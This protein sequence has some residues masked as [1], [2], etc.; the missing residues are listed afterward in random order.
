MPGSAI[1]IT[2]KTTIDTDVGSSD[3]V[4][5]SPAN[6]AVCVIDG[7]SVSITSFL[8]GVGSRPLVVLS[9][10][11]FDLMGTIDVASHASP[12]QQ[13][14]G[15]DPAGCAGTAA[16]GAPGGGFGGTFTTKGGNGGVTAPPG[17]VAQ[18]AFTTTT[19]R[20]GCPGGDGKTSN[21]NAMAG[22]GGGAVELIAV[23]S[24]VLFGT[25]NASGAGG[26]PG[27]GGGN[28]GYGAGAG[29]MIVLDSPTISVNGITQVFAN[30]GGAGGGG[31]MT[32]GM[33]GVSGSDP[34]GPNAPAASGDGGGGTGG[35]G[36]NG[37]YTMLNGTV[38]NALSGDDGGGGGG[39]GGGGGGLGFIHIQQGTA[40]DV[41]HFSPRPQ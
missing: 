28:G 34:A 25:I 37:A 11:T 31:A 20:G 12:A 19:L 36:G 15:S 3:C 7:T 6:N 8:I 38:V 10:S 35:I 23:Q 9:R 29:G 17:G 39:D 5:L 18:A 22:H 40:S 41:T 1:N 30:G 2:T 33:D 21:G 26:G 32:N 24:M 16:T 27:K 4:A 13:G 14:A